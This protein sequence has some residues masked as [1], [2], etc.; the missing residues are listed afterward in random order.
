MKLVEHMPDSSVKRKHSPKPR[1]QQAA[2]R[3]RIEKLFSLA[4]KEFYS[5]PE[6]SHRYVSLARKI[7]MRYNIRLPAELKRLYCKKC[8]KYLKPSINSRVRTNRVQRAVIVTCME[9]GHVMRYPYRR[10]KA[11]KKEGVKRRLQ[12]NEGVS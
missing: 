11:L 4:G 7:A 10:E 2:G 5:H 3:E 8:Y 12:A 9:C 1:W 6:R